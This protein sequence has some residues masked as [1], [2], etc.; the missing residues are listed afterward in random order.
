M[1]IFN[2][3]HTSVRTDGINIVESDPCDSGIYAL[4]T[5]ILLLIKALKFDKSQKKT[6]VQ[7]KPCSVLKTGEPIVVHLP[8]Q[9]F[10]AVDRPVFHGSR[11]MLDHHRDMRLDIDNM[12]YEVT[13]IFLSEQKGAPSTR[14]KDRKCLYFSL[15]LTFMYSE[16][17]EMSEQIGTPR[18]KRK[19]WECQHRLV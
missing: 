17:L 4:L 10:M 11:N 19:D 12:S 5:L 7:R 1:L 6:Y 15:P 2:Q 18:T 3:V 14:R 16:Y 8:L 13:S 9:G